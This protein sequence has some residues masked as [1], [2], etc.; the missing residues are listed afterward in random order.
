MEA[1]FM[2]RIAGRID[3]GVDERAAIV[4]EVRR[5]LAAS[6]ADAELTAIRQLFE[7]ILLP[8]TWTASLASLFRPGCEEVFSVNAWTMPP[9]FSLASGYAHFERQMGTMVDDIVKSEAGFRLALDLAFELAHIVRYGDT[10]FHS[11]FALFRMP[12]ATRDLYDSFLTLRRWFSDVVIAADDFDPAISIVHRLVGTFRRQFPLS[13]GIFANSF[14]DL[15]FGSVDEGTWEFPED[16]YRKGGSKRDFPRSIARGNEM[17]E[18]LEKAVTGVNG[19][20][21]IEWTTDDETRRFFTKSSCRPRPRRQCPFN[22][23]DYFDHPARGFVLPLTE[24]YSPSKHGGDIFLD[25]RE[26]TIYM[27]LEALGAGPPVT[28]IFDGYSTASF[29]IVTEEV[30]EAVFPV[31]RD[32]R[33][34]SRLSVDL[35][36][37]R[38]DYEER[39]SEN[40]VGFLETCF[41]AALLGLNDCHEH[42]LCS[43]STG[44][45]TATL[46]II[47]FVPPS[48]QANSWM[49]EWG[50]IRQWVEECG[51]LP[52]SA[53]P[54]TDADFS[55]ATASLGKKLAHLRPRP[56]PLAVYPP[57]DGQPPLAH[58]LD[59]EAR[60]E[61]ISEGPA[62]PCSK[63]V[64][65][66]ET[67]IWDLFFEQQVG[68]LNDRTLG[69][70][71]GFHDLGKLWDRG[72]FNEAAAAASRAS[73]RR[74]FD[75][76]DP[77][78]KDLYARMEGGEPAPEP[79]V[80]NPSVNY[81]LAQMRWF[82]NWLDYRFATF[83][84]CYVDRDARFTWTFDE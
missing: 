48:A 45:G 17:I 36:E 34:R 2:L 76:F 43:G 81:A 7:G 55:A 8:A 24:T 75:K 40:P 39:Y 11:L 5:A 62:T 72:R 59:F 38:R 66:I 47:D 58:L 49:P 63:F 82:S 3:C 28:F 50:Q 51:L 73:R 84:T 79:D 33:Q 13:R 26:I 83:Q 65:H 80:R 41:L 56:I 22:F 67:Q 64:L 37:Q 54:V 10:F 16:D 18:F 1:A 74:S 44:S 57:L 69:S 9:D 6:W 29:H 4:S 25:F 12:P 70:L 21:Q 68:K 15:L 19:G 32:G 35:D 60:G 61:P 71:F 20:V 78:W 46:Q 77:F 23:R 30:P 52:A 27:L 42:N 14:T 31:R 53:L